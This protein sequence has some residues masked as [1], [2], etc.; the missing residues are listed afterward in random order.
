LIR[1]IGEAFEAKMGN[2]GILEE[3]RR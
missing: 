2:E 3:A 1:Q